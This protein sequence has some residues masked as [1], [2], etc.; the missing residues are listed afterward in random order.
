M[1]DDD[2]SLS[3]GLH[4]AQDGKE[5]VCL[6]GGQNGGRLIQNQNVCAPVEDLDDFYSL[7]LGDGHVVNLLCGVNVK[8]IFFADGPHLFVGGLDIQLAALV[9]PQNNIFRGG[10]HVHQLIVLVDHANAVVI[11]ILRRTD[12][13]WFSID[14]NLPLVREVDPSQHIH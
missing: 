6:L 13:R 1:R 4:V 12:G 10:K 8:A 11:G 9:E 2:N 7:L 14:E 5:L 3:V